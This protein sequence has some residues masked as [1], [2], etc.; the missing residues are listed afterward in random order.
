MNKFNSKK[1]IVAAVQ[2]MEYLGD[3]IQIKNVVYEI[4][5]YSYERAEKLS[6]AGKVGSK[7]VIF[8]NTATDK[9]ITLNYDEG[10]VCICEAMINWQNTHGRDESNPF[11]EVIIELKNLRE[12]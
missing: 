11:G 7:E 6:S 8:Y 12:V 9:E 1:E 10:T 3:F 4:V 5:Y 2:R